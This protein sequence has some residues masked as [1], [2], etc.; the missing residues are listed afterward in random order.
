MQ[1][2]YLVHGLWMSGYACLYWRRVLRMAGF[3]PT[4]YSYPS[5]I[6][7]LDKNADKLYRAIQR[8]GIEADSVHLVGHSLGG[9]VIM[10]MLRRHGHKIPNLGRVVMCGSPINGS[11]CAS[12][13]AKWPVVGGVL[14]NSILEWEGITRTELPE[15]LE[16]GV[17][18]GTREVGL[19]RI[20][21]GLP[22]PSD[23][24][25]SLSETMLEGSNDQMVMHINHSEMLIAPA[26]GTQIIHFLRHG[27]FLH[28]AERMAVA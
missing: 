5:V 27:R 1:K 2:V 28:R 26:A 11:Y 19:G 8:D 6:N 10:H 7:H 17:L 13:G 25:V 9:I 16:I 24:T 4:I 14:G 15:Q 3:S 12:H 21:P 23:G 18:A 22:Q 20:V